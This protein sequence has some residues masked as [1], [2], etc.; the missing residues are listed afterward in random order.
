VVALV[1]RG[2]RKDDVTTSLRRR[3]RGAAKVRYYKG[4]GDRIRKVDQAF[5]AVVFD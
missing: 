2:K 4:L 3:K 1:R 5:F